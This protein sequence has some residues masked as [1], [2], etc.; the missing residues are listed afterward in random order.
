[1][2]VRLIYSFVFSDIYRLYSKISATVFYEERSTA[3]WELRSRALENGLRS[4]R[5]TCEKP[6]VNPALHGRH[7]AV[8]N[9][10]GGP[11]R[12]AL[13]A[14]PPAVTSV[15]PVPKARNDA[16]FAAV[17]AAVDRAQEADRRSTELS[18]GTHLC[19]GPESRGKDSNS[20]VAGPSSVLLVDDDPSVL[21]SVG[22]LLRQRRYELTT[23][24]NGAEAVK[25]VRERRF[26]VV[27]S[28]I[29]MPNMDGI[30]LLREIREHDLHIPVVLITGA[31]TV[32]TAVQALELG[33]LSYL[34]KPL[35]V[36]E[37]ERAIDKATRFHRM[38]RVQQQAAE[39]LGHT[40]A[41][42]AD[43]AGLEASFERAMASLWVAYQPIVRAEDG[44]V[45]GYEALLRSAEPSLPHPG[46]VLDAAERLE[47]LDLVGRTIRERAAEPM[48]EA[49]D[50]GMLF[51]NLHVLDLL[52]TSLFAA[53]VPLSQMASRVVLE[54]TERSSLAQVKD[55]R[56]RIAALREMGFRI[57]VDD[58][59]AGYAGLTSFALL[60][61]EIVKLDMT[62]V[63]DVH[64]SSTKQKI[65]R[66]MTALAKDMGM[67]VVAEGVEV[68][69][70]R[71]HL[72]KLGCELLQ[73]YLFAKPD[74]AFPE[75]RW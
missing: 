36:E 21:R 31:P 56:A 54:I 7:A 33:A 58:L 52:D 8:S 71:D 32:S 3:R 1:M 18:S 34:S 15:M 27:L 55:A 24:S 6:T 73:G 44:S 46:A 22:R 67:L 35:N 50:R 40:S 2:I 68:S 65:I 72:V 57:A 16:A 45:F 11:E 17:G 28:D 60:E 13:A 41:L 30:Q 53:G 64:K 61:P 63:R 49:P 70:E 69:E 23:A 29:A 5:N 43:R 38:A 19:A 39:L 4:A 10:H 51:V 12:R 47:R 75:A 9:C 48:L 66:S 74:R 14:A 42:G 26:D 25:L 62:L 20:G 37:V 59:G